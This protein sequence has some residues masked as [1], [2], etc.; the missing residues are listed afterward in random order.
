MR[1][2]RFLPSLNCAQ[3]TGVKKLLFFSFSLLLICQLFIGFVS[4]EDYLIFF[5]YILFLNDLY[6]KLKK[7][8]ILYSHYERSRRLQMSLVFLFLF[9]LPFIFDA[10]NLTDMMRFFLFKVGFILW[11][12]I[13]LL[14]AFVQ[15]RQTNSK[16]WLIITNLAVLFIVVGSLIK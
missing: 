9:L 7:P 13:F 15:Y 8:D 4:F 12:Q 1:F 2:L 16:R 14:D 5:I 11:A 3:L 10:F 6:I